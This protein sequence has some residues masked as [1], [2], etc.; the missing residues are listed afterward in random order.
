MDDSSLM[1]PGPGSK[2]DNRT[3]EQIIEDLQAFSS[4]VAHD[5]KTPLSYIIGF[6]ELLHSDF[7]QLS[8]DEI[9]T[10]LTQIVQ[11]AQRMNNII[12]ELMLLASV[13]RESVRVQPVEMGSILDKAQ[14]RL[15]YVI[16]EH[17]AAITRPE[18]W[19]TATGYAPWIEE[20]WVNYLSNA[21]LYGG[22]PPQISVGATPLDAGRVRFWIRDNGLGISSDEQTRLFRPFDHS[23]HPSTKGHG[24][25]LSIVR[26][27]VEKL[28]GSVG[29][30]SHPDQGSLFWFDLP[31]DD[32]HT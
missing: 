24:L 2:H 27:I 20:V 5:L 13:D 9:N 14:Y 16:E 6:A 15:R 18:Q 30:D 22:S 1:P 32:P 3:L 7:S 28:D 26:R 11:T 12:D 19:P 17:D 8:Q 10:C 23:R 29:V 4:T 21:I 31:G 25:G